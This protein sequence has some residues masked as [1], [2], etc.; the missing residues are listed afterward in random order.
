MR[1]FLSS[2][3]TVLFLTLAADGRVAFAQTIST[4][5][6]S[7]CATDDAGEAFCWGRP[8]WLTDRGTA[9]V[10]YDANPMGRLGHAPGVRFAAV[11]TGWLHI[12]A[13]TQAG[14]VICGGSNM[15]GELGRD[16]ACGGR[17]CAA[18]DSISSSE[19]FRSIVAGFSHTC[20]L[21]HDGRLFCWGS[22]EAGQTGIGSRAPIVWRPTQ[23]YGGYRFVSITAGARHTCGL[24]VG[25]EALCW[26]A[27]S[28][29]QLGI[30][31]AR[32][33][34]R[35]PDAC[36]AVP[37]PL[38]DPR[39]F[40]T[41]RAGYNVTCGITAGGGLY[42]WGYNYS[43][44]DGDRP[45]A[46]THIGASF[47][48][49]DVSPGYWFNCA[50][51]VGGLA[52]CWKEFHPAFIGRPLV[53]FGCR[54]ARQCID[55]TP[56]SP[57]LRFLKLAAAEQHACGITTDGAVYCWGRKNQHVN[58]EGNCDA[59][60]PDPAQCSAIPVRIGGDWNLLMARGSRGKDNP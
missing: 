22:N 43:A 18:P 7:T 45:L 46:L 31:T 16:S 27:N 55:E 36:T 39:R 34:C 35:L 21:T 15:Q 54:D 13:L 11:V 25:G 20:A 4:S 29:S 32:R 14:Q 48:F 57:S 33:G 6:Q 44:P 53:Q 23:V 56:V 9:P 59:G 17:S 47:A 51:A 2:A 8:A 10:P 19:R 41:L 12:C 37:A 24:T 28:S 38:D 26:G 49:R 42:C 40:V 5:Q 50:T 58:G 60:A 30:N 1:Q 3:F 52:Y